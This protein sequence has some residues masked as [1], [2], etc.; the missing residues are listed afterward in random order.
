MKRE[1]K[2]SIIAISDI[3]LKET[4]KALEISSKSLN[5]N[6]TLLLTSKS[7][8]LI[9]YNHDLIKIIKIDPISSIKEYSNFVIYN[10]YKYIKTSH[11]LI[12]QW[13]GFILN[14][15]KWDDSFYKYDYIGAPFIPRANDFKYCRDKNNNF[16]SVGNGG[17]TIRSR[18][19]LEAPTK[20]SLEDNFENTNFHED[21]FFSVY[22]R[23]FLESKGFKWAPF[24][25]AK[26][27]A[28]ESL[29]SFNDLIDLPLGFHGKKILKI[30]KLLLIIQNL[31]NLLKRLNTN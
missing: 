21:G 9:N 23:K 7:L 1:N 19:L 29:I 30:H 25:I 13:D 4:V 2:I 27:F 15:K 14:P 18:S 22:H 17:F 11:I 24:T 26:C 8:D 12:V 28:L 16:Y 5:P 20:F 10:L 6:E 3:K 31:S